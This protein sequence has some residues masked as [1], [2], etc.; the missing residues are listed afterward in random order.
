MR[1]HIAEKTKKDPD[2]NNFTCEICNRKFE[3]QAS[4]SRHL[5]LHKGD[6][7]HTCID[8][9][10]KFSHTFN[11]E[12]HRKKVHHSDPTGQYVRCSNCGTWFPSSMV[13]KV[14]MFSH[15]PNK[16][17]QNW[18]VED[19][20][21]QSGKEGSEQAAE[22]MKFQCPSEGCGCQYDT[23]LELVEHAGEHG[24]PYLPFNENAQQQA[25]PV[26][27]CELCY[28][29]FAN[30]VRLKKH[31]A[32]HAGNDTK[33]LECS[34]CGKR[35]LTNSALAGHI[36]THAHPDTLYDCPICLQ[37]F[38][39]VS[40]LK[41]HVYV[42]KENGVFTCPHCEK[43]FKE[44]P[45][46]RK[47]IR[48]FHA[49][50]RFPCTICEKSFT[51]KDKL[52]IHMVRH[53]EI[54]DFMCDDCGKQFKRKDK[55]REH[56]KRMHNNAVTK[57]EKVMTPEQNP[58][59]F[60]PKVSPT[61]LHRF[62]YKCHTCMLGFK[63]R[64]MLVNHLA[65][66]HPEVAPT[67]VPELN[68]PILKTTKDFY[69]QYCEK[70]YKSSSKRKSH[71]IKNH[72]GA[73]LP[74]GAREVNSGNKRAADA[75]VSTFSHTVGSVTTQPHNCDLC[76]KQY[77]SKAKLLQHMR[78]KHKDQAAPSTSTKG[79]RP[80]K[81]MYIDP[82]SPNVPEQMIEDS[83]DPEPIENTI[84]LSQHNFDSRLLV[85]QG[86]LF[87]RYE[88]DDFM[89]EARA[90]P[91][92]S[93]QYR[94]P[95]EIMKNE[96]G[97]ILTQAL[98]MTDL[99]PTSSGQQGQRAIY[100]SYTSDCPK[101]S[102]SEQNSLNHELQTPKRANNVLE[103]NT[104]ESASQNNLL[105]TQNRDQIL[106][107]PGDQQYILLQGSSEQLENYEEPFYHTQ[108]TNMVGNLHTLQPGQAISQNIPNQHNG[109]HQRQ[110][111]TVDPNQL[112]IDNSGTG[113]IIIEAPAGLPTSQLHQILENAGVGQCLSKSGP[114]PSS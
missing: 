52:K 92:D 78:K 56:V 106:R 33:P 80:A 73:A 105:H 26:H 109:D 9:G 20:M 95:N 62:I 87:T 100:H 39:Q 15:H 11:L 28:K 77:A 68:L 83:D 46:I 99:P 37:E 98:T 43:T 59:K 16:E 63:R 84:N 42:H 19:A 34:E 96:N 66:R 79:G 10:Q 65:K 57:K 21:A 17:E 18:T 49:E 91:S 3:R 44:Y 112:S 94:L 6:K 50:K 14:H 88:S 102:T 97:D 35:F 93:D 47:H 12:R 60:I 114:G 110:I 113:T 29:T 31:M 86:E 104:T 103:E 51:G 23:W 111:L 13:L 25:G 107:L 89:L 69:C 81:V 36:K 41:D 5:A 71:I 1:E 32:V 61:D 55:L 75:E 4:L 30:D 22:E 67:T 48:A 53:S 7:N 58:S 8:C 24:S 72:P 74:A 64:G 101:Q 27:K 38:E 76:H 108:T 70:V 45:N 85:E 90:G 40:S 82:P 2:S 54:K